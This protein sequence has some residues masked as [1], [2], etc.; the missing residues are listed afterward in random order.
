MV[1]P[2][3]G[4]DRCTIQWGIFLKS[5]ISHQQRAFLGGKGDELILSDDQTGG[6]KKPYEYHGSKSQPLGVHPM[7]LILNPVQV[8]QIRAHLFGGLGDLGHFHVFE[9]LEV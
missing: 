2:Y 3:H 9:L 4:G 7:I 1:G 8:L 6:S 5:Q